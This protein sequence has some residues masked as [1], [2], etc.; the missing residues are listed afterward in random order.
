LLPDRIRISK[1]T[2]FT[3][4]T[5][6]QLNNIKTELDINPEAKNKFENFDSNLER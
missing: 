3:Y 2:E 6:A 1:T 5:K 4:K